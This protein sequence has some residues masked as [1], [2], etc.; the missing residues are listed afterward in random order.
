MGKKAEGILKSLSASSRPFCNP[1]NL[2]KIF[3]EKGDDLIRLPVMGGAD[4]NG[5]C[6]EEWHKKMKSKCQSSNVKRMTNSK[7]F[8]FGIC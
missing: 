2:P 5:I 3:G 6:P 1:L 8:E 4:N 7:L